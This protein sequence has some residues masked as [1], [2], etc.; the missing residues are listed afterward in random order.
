MATILHDSVVVIVVVVVCTRPRT[1]LLAM[2]TMRKFIDRF[3]CISIYGM[4]MG[5]RLVALCRRS[6]TKEKVVNA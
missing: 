4:L 5:L 2:I 6:A 1:I 3:P